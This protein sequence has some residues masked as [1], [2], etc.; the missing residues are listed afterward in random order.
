MAFLTPQGVKKVFQLQK[1]EGREHLRNL[2]NWEKFDEV[3]DSR[4]S[5]LLDTFY[6]SIIFA[7]G[8][9]FP[10]VE[11]VQVVKFTQELLQETK[12]C[13]I[14]QAITILRNKLSDYQG[15]FNTTHLLALCDYF[16]NTFIR[17]YRLYQYVLGQ[18]QEV[19]LTINHVEVCVPPQ[20]L[21]LAEGKDRDLCNLEQQLAELTTAEMQKR[22][23]VLLLKEAL[24]LEQ[25]HMLQKKFSEM[26]VQQRRVL[27][28]EELEN[29]INEAIHIQ[30]KCLKELLQYEIQTT[31][32]IL[33]LKLQ[34]KTLNLNAPIPFP[35]S[36][37]GQPGQDESLKT[38][39]ARKAKKAKDKRQSKD[40]LKK[41]H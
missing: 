37:S 5:I 10:W 1:P 12:G 20:P 34:K 38:N 15:Q 22:T 19:N 41:N 4:R 32:D 8:K 31:F 26:A 40:S 13:S 16:Y 7:V 18:D 3:R 30:I 28:R 33:D 11:V 36:I 35:L 39:K 9:G 24:H 14:T 29:L 21:P 25:E 27:K 2:L 6:E 17:H 23:N